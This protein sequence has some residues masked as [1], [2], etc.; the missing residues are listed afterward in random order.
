MPNVPGWGSWSVV[1]L[2]W[3]L[4][5]MA[6]GWYAS[7]VRRMERDGQS[8]SVGGCIAFY[9]GLLIILL[10]LGSPL[11][12]VA[13]N[14]LLLGAMLQH[15]LVADIAPP[16]FVLG[17]APII[18]PL[19][20]PE[21]IRRHFAAGTVPARVWSVV[22]RPL[23]AVPLW[24]VTLLSFSIPPVFDFTV[25]HPL[26]HAGEHVL[27]FSTGFVMWWA[28]INPVHDA[29]TDPGMGRVMM[30][31]ASRGA[32]ALV[33]LPLTFLNTTLF[34]YYSNL[35]RGFSISPI[36]DQRLAG[37]SMCLIEFLVFGIAVAIVFIDALNRTERADALSDLAAAN[38]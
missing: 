35:P 16:L 33:C 19:A 36:N 9:S 13:D 23:I 14:W 8:V 7:V 3:V 34:S 10:A 31:A 28:I 5:L 2:L 37:A 15:T 38:H 21:G 12:T 30:V 18:S 25:Q 27:L 20:L 6:G 29:A 17:I 11:N 4:L 1:P 26:V 22:T 24:S 32:A